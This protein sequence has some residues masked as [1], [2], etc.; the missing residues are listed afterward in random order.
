MPLEWP[1]LHRDAVAMDKAIA[2]LGQHAGIRDLLKR[3]Q[4][5]K[6]TL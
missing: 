1:D 2:E 3:A 5:I 4:E 6:E